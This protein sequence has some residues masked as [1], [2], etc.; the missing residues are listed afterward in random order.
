MSKTTTKNINLDISEKSRYTIN[1][2]ADKFIELNPADMGLIARLGDCVPKLNELAVQY[3][4]L[5]MHDDS[6]DINAEMQ[7]FSETFKKIDAEMRSI[8]NYLF[9]YDVCSVC[10]NGGSM[11]DLQNGEY[12]F[13]VIISTLLTLYEDVITE[14][15]TKLA[16]K[17]KKHLDKY[18]PKDRQS[19]KR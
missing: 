10:A 8:I 3:E 14:E 19:K 17:M 2:N 15:T 16:N 12:R 4:E 18:T 9:D 6:G 7:K 5:L 11:L 13:S 1:G